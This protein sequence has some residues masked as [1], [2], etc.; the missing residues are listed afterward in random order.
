MERENVFIA[1]P[2][3]HRQEPPQPER[4]QQGTPSTPN[5]EGFSGPLLGHEGSQE[6]RSRWESIQARFIDDPMTV[7]K[8]ADELV[9]TAIKRLSETFANERI[10]LERQWSQGNTAST[11]DLRLALR[12]YRAFFNRLLVV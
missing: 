4:V 12:K 5:D 1:E 8:E 7:V 6:M 3:E 10:N 2:Q 9:A 11:E